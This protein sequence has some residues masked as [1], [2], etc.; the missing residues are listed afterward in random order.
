MILKLICVAAGIYAFVTFGVW[1]TF[2]VVVGYGL[3]ELISSTN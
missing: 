3:A 2:A 1:G